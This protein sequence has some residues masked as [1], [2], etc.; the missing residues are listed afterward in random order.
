M[1]LCQQVQIVKGIA[2]VTLMEISSQKIR[3]K[4]ESKIKCRKKETRGIR[5]N[6]YSGI[7]IVKEELLIQISNVAMMQRMNVS[8]F[9]LCKLE[10]IFFI[11]FIYLN[12]FKY[13]FK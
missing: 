5:K 2:A 7:R 4:A 13:L 12:S 9:D 11:F 6:S 3:E 1:M 8:S 10:N